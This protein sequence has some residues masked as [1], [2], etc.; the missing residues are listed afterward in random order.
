[1]F[2]EEWPLMMFTLFSQL[3]VG[4][5]LMLLIVRTALKNKDAKA[6]SGITKFG[7]TV[8]GVIMLVALILSLFHLGSPAGAYRSISN[9]GSSWLSREI[10]TAGGF[11]VL[12]V[13]SY[14]LERKGKESAG[15]NWAIAVIGLVAVFCMA[16]IYASSIR[17]AWENVNT[18]ISFFGTT[19][20]FGTVGALVA[21]AYG[22]KGKTVTPEVMATLKKISLVALLAVAVQLIYLPI[23][24]SGLASA[25]SAGSASAKLLATGYAAPVVIRWLLSLAGGVLAVYALNKKGK[26]RMAANTLYLA[27]VA[28]LVGE[29]IG[30]FVFYATAVSTMIGLN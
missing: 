22:M 8:T 27:L 14:L 4:M 5:F 12:W 15:L 19:F 1:M 2:S 17:P 10:L 9:L 23:Y 26:G 7:F 13:V 24:I 11:F 3:A 30:R 28:I 6:A 29:F 18:Y 25:G 16:S 20:L 21:I